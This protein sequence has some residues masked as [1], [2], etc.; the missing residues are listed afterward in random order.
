MVKSDVTTSTWCKADAGEITPEKG[1]RRPK[2]L[3]SASRSSA[4]RQTEISAALY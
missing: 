1:G 4:A 2:S 3:A